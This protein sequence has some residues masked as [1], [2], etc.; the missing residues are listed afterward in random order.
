MEEEDEVAAQRVCQRAEGFKRIVSS[1]FP[2]TLL[3]VQEAIEHR[4]EQLFLHT[5]QEQRALKRLV[6][7]LERVLEGAVVQNLQ[8]V[9]DRELIPNFCSSVVPWSD[10]SQDLPNTDTGIWREGGR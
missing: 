8:T 3:R 1:C 9:R 7:Q 2:L 4:L 6:M 10:D 5:A